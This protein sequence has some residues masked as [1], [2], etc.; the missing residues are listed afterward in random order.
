M[1]KIYTCCICNR[2]A[3][4]PNAK[5]NCCEHRA[6]DE[7]IEQHTQ[8]SLECP[9]CNKEIRVFILSDGDYVVVDED[10]DEDEEEEE[11]YTKKRDRE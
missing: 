11:V 2:T 4:I 9:A 3:I 6:C 10:E 1:T 7:C 5:W 8:R